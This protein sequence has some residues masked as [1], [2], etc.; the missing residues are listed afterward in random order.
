MKVMFS[1]HGCTPLG[2][3]VFYR[4]YA[5][6]TDILTHMNVKEQSLCISDDEFSKHYGYD[7]QALFHILYQSN[8]MWGFVCSK[9]R[10]KP[11]YKIL[12]SNNKVNRVEYD[13]IYF[14]LQMDDFS[15]SHWAEMENDR[16]ILLS[17]HGKTIMKRP[18]PTTINKAKF[19]KKVFGLGENMLYQVVS[20]EKG[21]PS[22][23]SSNPFNS[24]WE[25]YDAY[26]PTENAFEQWY[27]ID[28][29][30]NSPWGAT[31]P[32]YQKGDS[33]GKTTLHAVPFLR[34]NIKPT[35]FAVTKQVKSYENDLKM[36]I[37]FPK[38]LPI[39]LQ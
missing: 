18:S 34:D 16:K 7:R 23:P 13:D 24:Q 26:L 15:F 8:D 35:T 12:N 38:G 22:Y 11:A 30:N 3:I 9:I 1:P 4:H 20:L 33:Q 21:S 36:F 25:K 5:R 39:I 14:A 28:V 31:T 29:K 37:N 17:P 6:F 32:Y 19:V 10:G 2:T 27:N